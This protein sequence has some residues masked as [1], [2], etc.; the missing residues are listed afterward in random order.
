MTEADR[1]AVIVIPAY[2]PTEA[3]VRLVDDLSRNGDRTIVVVNDG[4][5]AGC[6][7]VFDRVSLS[8][9]VVVLEHAANLG[10]G[11]ALKTAFNYVLVYE[12]PGTVGVVTADADGQHLAD[13][14][15]RVAERLEAQPS[16]LVLGSRGFDGRVPAR[17]ALGNALTRGVFRLLIGRSLADTQTGLR[18]IPRA[19]LVDLIQL[20]AGRYEFE[21]E[22]LVR[23][24]E[25]GLPIDEVRIETVYGGVAQSH[26]NPLRD[27]VRIYFV[28]LRFAGLSIVTAA[29]DY[30][31][32]AIVYAGARN[33]LLATIVARAIAG[34]VN[35]TANRMLVF[36]SRGSA[37]Q[38]AVRYALLVAV[39][40]WVS[41]GLV[42][43]LVLVLGLGVYVSKFLAEGTLFAASFA[44]Q[45]LVVFSQR[46]RGGP[47]GPA[48]RTD[49]DAYYRAPALLSSITRRITRRVVVS[50]VLKATG[51]SALGRIVELGGGDSTC[52]NALGRRFPEAALIAVDSNALG[53]QLLR[54][55]LPDSPRLTAIE[56]DVLGPVGASLDGDL[57]Y[58]VGLIEHFDPEQT[59]RVIDAHFTHARSGAVVLLT[60]PTPTWLYRAIRRVAERAGLWAFP[61]ERPLQAGEVVAAVR[62][63][64]E[65][66]RQFVNWPILL[67]QGIVVAR[68]RAC[69]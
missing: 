67:T 61:D 64:G 19:F 48:N 11:Q 32:F 14:V 30:T 1:R 39:L 53:L 4:S 60:F 63:H 10:K 28:F 40:M 54:R 59:A 26:F 45:H 34:V 52:L 44:L 33:I 38:E 37:A 21:L 2:E 68:K 47:S 31:A 3:L 6:R 69:K 13:D 7:A 46:G 43:T 5:S 35:F 9:G 62:R 36:R 58:S 29:I 16:R 65:V 20:E 23:A 41:Y 8:P 51:D 12:P 56:A 22:M 57:V 15:R 50:E 25:Q 27:S 17:S 24:T 49:W 18:G 42:T 66:L 55:Q